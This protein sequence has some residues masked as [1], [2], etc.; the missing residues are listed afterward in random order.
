MRFYFIFVLLVGCSLFKRIN[1]E[2]ATGHFQLY[3]SPEKIKVDKLDAH[4]SRLVVV[5]TNDWAG[6]LEAQQVTAH[7]Q[8][9]PERTLLS[10]GGVEAFARYLEI[11]REKFQGQVLLVDAGNS[12]AGSLIARNTNGRAVVEAFSLLKYDAI[13]LAS[14]DFAAG[15]ELRSPISPMQWMPKLFERSKTPVIISNLINL[16][17]ATPVEW[18]NTTPQLIK[19]ING[20][21]VGFISLLPDD[22]PKKLDASVLN[23]LYIEPGQL[24]FLRQLRSLRLKGAEVIVLI[25]HG[26]I[27]CGEVKAREKNLPLAKVNFDP[28]DP[29]VCDK[30]D[31][32]VSFLEGLPAGSVDLVLT[33][34]AKGKV[35]NFINDIPVVQAIGGGKSFSR[36]EL[37]WDKK[38]K[39]VL[40]E[41]TLIHQPTVVCHRFFK[42]TEDCF[43]ADPSVDHRNLVPARF[44]GETIFSDSLTAVLMNEWRQNSAEPLIEN[45]H[46]HNL[47][48]EIADSLLATTELDVALIGSQGWKLML[49]KGTLSYLDLYRQKAAREKIFKLTL[50]GFEL[51][52]LRAHIDERGWFASHTPLEDLSTRESISVGMNEKLWYR[53]QRDLF[54]GKTA[55]LQSLIIA[56]TLVTW[57]QDSVQTLASGRSPALPRTPD[58]VPADSTDATDLDGK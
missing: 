51:Q 20:V 45:F 33:G 24:S 13:G 38:A 44:L 39:L 22:L 10:V 47:G 56:D 43:E 57:K 11:L 50:S 40:R 7:D 8:F 32:F 9:S 31:P 26:G 30:T 18:G 3:S 58:E 42:A 14:A 16:K 37:F 41:R 46:P 35:A 6:N 23:G 27:S 54:P 28:R 36:V 2:S 15:P 17:K 55:E 34:G 21:K 19:S 5:A 1:N 4:V 53:L 49:P 29:N 52:S 48:Q 12:L 25:K